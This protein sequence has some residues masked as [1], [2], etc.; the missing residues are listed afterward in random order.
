M[1]QQH[2]IDALDQELRKANERL[3]AADLRIQRLEQT[4]EDL[5]RTFLPPPN[6][7]PPHY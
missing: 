3:E 6:E 2:A 5:V 1:S 7:R 4:V